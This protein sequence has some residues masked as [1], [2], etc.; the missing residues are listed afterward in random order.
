MDA[1]K[2][3]VKKRSLAAR[4]RW[5]VGAL[6]VCYCV[7]LGAMMAFQERLIFPREAPGPRN[8]AAPVPPGW[9]QITVTGEDGSV[10]PAW[11]NL[12]RRREGER[13]GAVMFFHGNGEV[14]DEAAQSDLIE[15]YHE[16]GVTVMV[17]EYRGYGRAWVGDSAP[18]QR[19][20]VADSVKF[21]DLLAARPEIDPQKIVYYGRSLGGGVACAVAKE[22]PP[23]AMILQSTFLSIRRIAA[24]MG[25]PG[26]LVRHPFRNDEVVASLDVPIL[27]MHGTQDDVIPFW[28][29]QELLRLAKHARLVTQDCHHNDFP[30]DFE[31][32]RKEIEGFLREVG[33]GR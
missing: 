20:I 28:H 31:G 21:R 6:L 9:E 11:L 14:I 22:R 27:I 12:A 25:V 16:M 29:G 3:P 2:M 32:Y 26:F 1:V 13:V 23:R 8:A 24:G 10:V 7:Y 5:I 30:G 15:M 4:L 33:V 19:A 18:S 17:V